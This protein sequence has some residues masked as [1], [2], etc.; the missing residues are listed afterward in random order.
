MA[1]K[2]TSIELTAGQIATLVC[3]LEV[4]AAKPGNVHR[5]ADFEDA[6]LVDFLNSGVALGAAIDACENGKMSSEVT[7]VG[8][9]IFS[10]VQSTAAITDT[11]TNL[12]IVLLLCPLAV[13]H[14]QDSPLTT[15]NVTQIVASMG[16]EDA[17]RVYDAI[18]QSRAGGL[19]IE[20]GVES[21]GKDA[22]IDPSMDVLNEAPVEGNLMSAMALAADRDMIAKQY[23]SGFK[24]V[25]EFVLPAIEEGLLRLKSLCSAIIYAHV[26]TMAHFPD[27]LI[28]R[29]LGAQAAI[30]SAGYARRA[31][32]QFEK[33]EGDFEAFWDSVADLDFWLRSDHHRRNPGTTADL[34][35]AA[36][37]IGVASGR[38][39]PPFR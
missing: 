15:E 22:A 29:K 26:K 18:A 6:T 38:L 20:A 17:R 9:L 13:L 27:S 11:N 3:Q 32:D 21:V 34:I 12:G 5:A 37:Y 19:A 28:A 31:I 39:T 23:C 1:N 35:T 8:Q 14:H 7:S 30:D 33:C 36:L 24:D 2:K 16:N 4:A 25:F 10:A